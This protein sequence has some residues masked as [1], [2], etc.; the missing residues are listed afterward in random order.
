MTYSA[1][2]QGRW[3]AVSASAG[4]NPVSST[5]YNLYSEPTAVSYG[6]SDSDAFAFDL[7]TG[8]MTQYK[9]TL[10]GS[11]AYGNL[12]WNANGSLGQ[13]AITDPFNSANAQTCN[14]TYDD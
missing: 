1:D 2:G 9:T 5:S 11:S 14:Y 13:L 10:S 6:S 7:N 4:Q 3:N 12:N 8:R